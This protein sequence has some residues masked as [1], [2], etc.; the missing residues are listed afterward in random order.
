[1][2][3]FLGFIVCLLM[4]IPCGVAMMWGAIDALL[5]HAENLVLR[6][7]VI[8]FCGPSGALL[9]WGSFTYLKEY[10]FG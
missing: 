7:S 3:E 5:H 2:D 4:G 6:L 9:A 8:F 1:M 10:L